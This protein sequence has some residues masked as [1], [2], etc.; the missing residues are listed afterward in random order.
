VRVLASLLILMI[1]LPG[2]HASTASVPHPVA[3]LDLL[4]LL[5]PGQLDPELTTI[6]FVSETSIAVRLCAKDKLP[7][8]SLSIIRWE[9]VGWENG[10][11]RPTAHLQQLNSW[12]HVA[13][14]T[15]GRVLATCYGLSCNPLL[16]SPDLST[17]L[18]LPSPLFVVSP[19]GST[20]AT[21][22]IGGE[23]PTPK[24][25]RATHG[26]W[27]IYHLASTLGSLT[28]EPKA[29]EPIRDG[30]GSLRSISDEF[31][32]IQDGST[33]RTETL[34]GQ[35]LGSFPVQPDYK[36]P[37]QVEPLG[38][39]RLYLSDCKG[40]RIADFN[41]NPQLKMR[42]PKGWSYLENR[43][44]PNLSPWSA[45]GHRILF[46]YK[47]REVS[48]LRNGVSIAF[49]LASLLE[50]DLMQCCNRQ[51]VRVVDTVTGASCFRWRQ[52]F[53]MH[54]NPYVAPSLSPSG[55]FL[56]I[57][58]ER[59]LSIYRLPSICESR[60]VAEE[61]WDSPNAWSIGSRSYRCERIA[62]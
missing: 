33:M 12:A 60:K 35:L 46:D 30:T 36:C 34:D 62:P 2:A 47:S 7:R 18:R 55:E 15:D 13:P 28:P 38:D 59:T 31:V 41:G 16:Y 21:I 51:E 5:P 6:A 1:F 10:V 42:P 37:S 27:K 58:A 17:S 9:K 48:S 24:G 44:A 8:C 43:F 50:V 45:N 22:T 32:V 57:A 40:V 52:S 54:S 56:A 25:F 61:G 19:S 23:K 49:S 14:A 11:L 3:T 4:S 53:P 39:N 26:G 29:L 20:V